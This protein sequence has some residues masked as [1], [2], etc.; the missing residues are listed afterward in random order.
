MRGPTRHGPSPQPSP[1]T[2]GN[3]ARYRGADASDLQGQISV[4]VAD[5]LEGGAKG[6]NSTSSARPR[7]SQASPSPHRP[8]LI[9]KRPRADGILLTKRP[10][11]RHAERPSANS[12]K[13]Q[14]FADR[15]GW[16]SPPPA[17]ALMLF[18]AAD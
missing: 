5:A 16:Q 14:D 7:L 13:S 9:T 2:L 4:V 18:F 12:A 11:D 3:V 17:A 8:N 1:R 10:R 15:T 6:A